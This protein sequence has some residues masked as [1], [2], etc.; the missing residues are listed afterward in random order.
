MTRRQKRGC[1]LMA[2]SLALVLSALCLHL[3]Q[4]QRDTLAGE[5][6]RIL[7]RQLELSRISLDLLPEDESQP[8]I[9]QDQEEPVKEYLGYSMLGTLRI[10][11]LDME[12]PI[13]SSWS[14]ELL[15]AAPCRYSGSLAGGD[16]ILMGHNYRSHFTPLH[17]IQTGAAVEFE[18]VNG[19]VHHYT[20]DRIDRL[21][22]SEAEAL[23]SEHPLI[24]FTCTAGGQNRL[25]IRCRQ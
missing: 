13:L 14:Y 8:Q 7:L 11:E 23:P 18:D 12:L 2:I 6:S 24:L 15:N 22:K 5:N 3:A 21:H 25:V 10:D 20:V 1:A 9:Y 19:V 4:E 16:M 17:W